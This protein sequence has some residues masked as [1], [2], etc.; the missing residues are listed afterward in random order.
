ML[1]QKLEQRCFSKHKPH[2]DR[3]NWPWPSNSSERWT[4]HIFP[5]EFVANPF[6][7]S[8]GIRRKPRFCPWWPW[9]LAFDLDIQILPSE[10]PNASSLWI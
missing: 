1:K 7:G 9:H 6:S 3:R 10:G 8:R 5:C 2:A 4:K